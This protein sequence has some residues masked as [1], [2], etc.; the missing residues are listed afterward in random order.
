M[1]T[2]DTLTAE[3]L[4]VLSEVID[5]FACSG[6]VSPRLLANGIDYVADELEVICYTIGDA[7]E[8]TVE[9][10]LLVIRNKLRILSKLAAQQGA[11]AATLEKEASR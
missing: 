5:P 10:I 11:S 1:S 4:A 2:N 9:R 6:D 7:N 8:Q 3:Q